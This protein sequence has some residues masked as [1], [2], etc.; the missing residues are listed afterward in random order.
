MSPLLSP[1]ERPAQLFAVLPGAQYTSRAH[2]GAPSAPEDAFAAG[3]TGIAVV[4]WRTRDGVAVVASDS[5]PSWRRRRAISRSLLEQVSD[6]VTPLGDLVGQLWP[7]SELL[8]EVA[9]GATLDALFDNASM[10]GLGSRLWVACPAADQLAERRSVAGAARLLVRSSV[11]N[12]AGGPER[13]ASDMRDS[14]IDGLYAPRTDWS[15]GLTTLLHRFGRLAVSQAA[16]HQRMITAVLRV[17]VDAVVSE[18]PERLAAAAVE[19][20]GLGG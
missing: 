14:G 5:T 8:V 18:H 10:C 17:G 9:D 19:A 11:E 7:V 3:A 20:E 6:H 13:G 2:T 12:L 15:G 4:A 1:L 16:T